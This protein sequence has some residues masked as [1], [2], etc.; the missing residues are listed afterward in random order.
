MG[1]SHRPDPGDG[2]PDDYRKEVA[3]RRWERSRLAARQEGQ[4]GSGA[5]GKSCEESVR[6]DERP[7]HRGAAAAA[8]DRHRA[9]GAAADADRARPGDRGRRDRRADDGAGGRRRGPAR[10]GRQG[11]RATC[12]AL[13]ERRAASRRSSP[14]RPTDVRTMGDV[15]IRQAA[16]TSQPA[17][18]D[19]RSRR[20]KEGG[21]SEGSKV[22]TTLLELRR[23]VEDLDPSRGHRRQEAARHDPVRRQG[24]STTSASTSRAQSHLDGILHA[25]RDGQDEL[26]QGQRRA[27]PGEAATCGTRWAGSTSTSTS[28]SGSTPGSPAKIAELEA[29]DPDTGQGAARGR[30]VLRP[31]EAPGP[32]DPAGRVDPEL[33][34]DRHRHQEQHRADQGRRPRLD[35]DGL[36]AAHRR[37]RRPGAGQ[38]EAGA[39]PDHRA[40]HHDVRDDRAHL[41]DAQGQLGRDPAAGGVGRRSACRSCRRRSPTS[42]RRWT[43]STRSRCRRSTPWPRPSARWRP[44]SASPRQLPR[45]RVSTQDQRVASGSLDLGLRR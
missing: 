40:E 18:A 45:P 17:A 31:A 29:T 20:C 10:P 14:P 7:E 16:E 21:L 39:R 34:G 3:P 2:D 30:A 28:P 33:P 8:A 5:R 42:T 9:L 25:L 43:R 32:A 23:T 35:H 44:R 26:Q 38:P 1:R 24:R 27:Q 11:R 22:G 12:S 4:R 15:D 37:H 13:L 41:R 19:R 36:G 6:P